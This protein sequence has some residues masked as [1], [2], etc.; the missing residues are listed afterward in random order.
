MS[1]DII[2]NLLDIIPIIPPK[3]PLQKKCS[4]FYLTEG[5]APSK[6]VGATPIKKGIIINIGSPTLG[7]SSKRT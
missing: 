5:A 4:L 3:D 7:V 2:D 1:F 6:K